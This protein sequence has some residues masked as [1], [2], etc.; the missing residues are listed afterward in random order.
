MT[1]VLIKVMN[2]INCDKNSNNIPQN[3]CNLDDHIN[4]YGPQFG[5]FDYGEEIYILISANHM[6]QNHTI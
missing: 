3:I 5:K 4:T 6:Y 1:L 2:D